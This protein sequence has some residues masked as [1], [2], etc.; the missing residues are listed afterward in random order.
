MSD[1]KPSTAP[2]QLAGRVLGGRYL[3][4]SLI[5]QGGMGEVW[6]AR[7]RVTGRTLAA[8]VLRPEL[9]G[10]EL[11]LSRLRIEARTSRTFLI[12]AKKTAVAGSSWNSLRAVL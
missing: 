2:N 12:L 10:Q 8:K 9:S 1:S 5:A 6:K 3:L 11:S 7:D 4:L